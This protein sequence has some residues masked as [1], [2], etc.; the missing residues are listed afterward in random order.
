[1]IIYVYVYIYIYTYINRGAVVVS[2]EKRVF[3]GASRGCKNVMGLRVSRSRVPSWGALL[4]H[5]G[6]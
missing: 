4:R 2:Q 3:Q 6:V 5:T 1:M